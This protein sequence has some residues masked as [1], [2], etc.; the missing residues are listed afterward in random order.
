MS[1]V[2]VQICLSAALN[3]VCVCS[4]SPQAER[5]GLESGH[6]D[7]LRLHKPAVRPHLLGSVQGE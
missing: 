4:L 2:N 7:R 5:V 1:E 6:G 3:C